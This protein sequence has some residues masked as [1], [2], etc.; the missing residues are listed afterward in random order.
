MESHKVTII[1]IAVT[2]TMMFALP[3]CVAQFAPADAGM[4]LCMILFLIVNPIYSAILGY[5][6]GRN[7]HQMWY[8]PLA[9]SIAFL[10][11]TWLFFDI[12]EV[13]FIIYAAAY[14]IIGCIAMGINHVYKANLNE[15]VITHNLT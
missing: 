10:A 8:L 14:L 7:I 5:R 2:I 12:R 13:W 11:G 3:F 15:T 9:S 4:A 6:C 1:W